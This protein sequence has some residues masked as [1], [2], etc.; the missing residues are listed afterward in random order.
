MARTLNQRDLAEAFARLN[1][2]AE[3]DITA[4]EERACF[5]SGLWRTRPGMTRS[6]GYTM[7]V[8]L[9]KDLSE[10]K[11]RD[12][13]GEPTPDWLREHE[14][15]I[16]LKEAVLRWERAGGLRVAPSDQVAYDFDDQT[17]EGTGARWLKN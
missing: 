12:R 8:V 6:E 17:K 11:E 7:S 13:Y 4:A 2:A 14:V 3:Y 1:N 15:S 9:K 16:P 5:F 10:C